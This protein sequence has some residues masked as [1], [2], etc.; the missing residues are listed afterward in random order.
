M[1]NKDR[2]WNIRTLSVEEL[3]AL[4]RLHPTDLVK[5]LS[6]EIKALQITL[7]QST[8]PAIMDTLVR[9]LSTVAEVLQAE[10]ENR[11]QA[12]QI[13]AE[14]F[15]ERCTSFHLQLKLY[16]DR[17]QSPAPK[18]VSPSFPVARYTHQNKV[19]RLC[20]LFRALLETLSAST[21]SCLP[22]DELL[23]SVKTL[24]L[25]PDSGISSTLLQET[26]RIV[27]LRD[28]M[29]QLQVQEKEAPKQEWDN[30]EYRELQNT[31]Q[32][33]GSVH[34]RPTLQASLKYHQGS[35]QGLATLL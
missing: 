32:V 11:Q 17:L 13:L 7:E 35:L 15:S 33:E 30:S 26:Q 31:P 23:I 1:G 3:V 4:S 8:K 18:Y 24:S 5:R 12:T 21:W 9:I 25:Q 2:S 27:E 10:D 16:V 29:K 22:V 34:Q 6:G 28:Q 19:V 20:K 14:S